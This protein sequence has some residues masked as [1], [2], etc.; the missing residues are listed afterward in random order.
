[1]YVHAICIIQFAKHNE[2]SHKRES[3]VLRA[4]R[5]KEVQNKKD[6]K[7]TKEPDYLCKDAMPSQRSAAIA[8]STAEPFLAK[9][10][11]PICAHSWPFVD[12]APCSQTNFG[13]CRKFTHWIKN[14]HFSV[15]KI[16]REAL[17][18]RSGQIPSR[19]RIWNCTAR[20][21]NWIGWWGS[22]PRSPRKRQRARSHSRRTRSTSSSCLTNVWICTKYKKVRNTLFM[23]TRRQSDRACRGCFVGQICSPGPWNPLSL[24]TGNRARS[25]TIRRVSHLRVKR[26]QPSSREIKWDKRP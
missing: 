25:H 17:P 26:D 23:T 22:S 6:E 7:T 4:K 19:W 15:Y 5:E 24:F 3:C 13:R 20:R 11:A 16:N 18:S 10:S 9:I 8:A 12:T 21:S 2:L 14:R 1:M